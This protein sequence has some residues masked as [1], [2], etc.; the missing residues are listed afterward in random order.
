MEVIFLG[1]QFNGKINVDVRDSTPDWK[2][3]EEPKAPDGA[4]NVLYIV[5]DDVGFG[6]FEIYGGLIKT[7]NLKRI[8][9][10]GLTYTQFHTTALC[11]PTRSCLL[12]GRNA[13]SNGMACIAEASSGFPG[14]D[15]RIPPENAMIAE[16][17]LENGWNTYALGKWHETPVEE[18]SLANAKRTWP[19]ARGFERYYGFLGGESDQYYPDLI[20]DNHPVDPPYTPKEGYHL[21]KDLA[22]KAIRFIRD[23]KSV[24][25][26]KPWL[27]YWCSG[28]AHAP[29]HVWKDWADKYKGKFD[30]GYEKYREIV[31]DNQKKM[32]LMPENTELPPINPYADRKSADEKPWPPLDTVRPWDSLSEDEKKLFCRMAEVWAGYITYNDAQIGRILDYLQDSGQLEN[33]IIIVVADNGASGEGGPNGSVNE[34]KFFNNVPDN[35]EENM[36]YLDVLGTDKTYNH[37]CTGWAM[38]FCTPFKLWKRYA[39]YE[40]GIAD[41]CIVAWPKGIKSR[42]EVRHQYVH[43]IDVVPTIYD[44]LGIEPPEVVKGYTQNPIEGISFKKTFDDPKAI[45]GKE[46]Q[47]YTMLGTRGIWHNG[48]HANTIHP[49]IG[50]WSNFDKDEWEL[51][52]LEQDRNQMNNLADKYPE[53]LEKM[54]SLWFYEAGK[55]NGLPLDDRTAEELLTTPRPQVTKLRQRYVYYPD[56][57]GVSEAVSANIRGRS[58]SI[59]AEVQVDNDKAEGVLFA[60]GGR[61]GGHCLYIKDGKLSYVYNWF[62]EK[63]QKLTSNVNI[64][65]GKCILGLRFRREGEEGAG[66]VGMAALYIN[67]Q[68]VAEEKIQ[69]QLGMFSLTGSMLYVG[70]DVGEPASSD[71]ESPFAFTGGTIK[72]VTIDVSGEHFRDLEKELAAMLARE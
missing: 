61:F 24:S 3:Y 65:A 60:Q 2:P 15:A 68:K 21:S 12:T 26:E 29:H 19:L 11:S 30:M 43:A 23:A 22:D 41:A 64:P 54:K 5:W 69:T 50:G 10:M 57:A 6:A 56:C 27:M 48:W 8:A 16:V 36:K 71:Y 13:T 9:D 7:P 38:A 72:Q 62:G 34:N 53:K 55:Y 20:Y 52:D 14:S 45:T 51:Y 44:C 63:E 58:Y 39:N 42:G 47:F 31:L 67:D 40:G 66:T 25:P 46:T 4:P 49:A 35:M 28:C 32:G 59:A 18:M 33:T 17:L 70:R 37:F 1:K